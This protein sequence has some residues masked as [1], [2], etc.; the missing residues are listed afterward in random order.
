MD[1]SRA[2]SAV[3]TRLSSHDAV[4]PGP[5]ADG[6]EYTNALSE[7]AD[8][9][10]RG[11]DLADEIGRLEGRRS[12]LEEFLV[13]LLRQSGDRITVPVDGG[14]LTL[15]AERDEAAWFID[16]HFEEGD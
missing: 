2:T 8:L 6:D 7:Y 16:T 11:L 13:H 15:W 3:V 14:F 10:L 5:P 4:S 9:T 12:E 1:L